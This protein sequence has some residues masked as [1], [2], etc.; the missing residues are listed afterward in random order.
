MKL[1]AIPIAGLLSWP[2]IHLPE[3]WVTASRAVNCSVLFV[4][5]PC[6][7][8]T[9]DTYVPVFA[10]WV[11]AHRVRIKDPFVAYRTPCTTGST[12]HTE[13]GFPLEA[14][15]GGFLVGDE[16]QSQSS[17]CMVRQADAE[18]A[19]ACSALS[20]ECDVPQG[21]VN[22]GPNSIRISCD[23]LSESPVIT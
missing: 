2:S 7:V 22:L 14:S 3:L 19:L 20:C 11:G 21:W 18:S 12:E 8:A 5:H 23:S 10:S 1:A 6:I 4:S 13:N 15:W 16:A 17:E 9:V